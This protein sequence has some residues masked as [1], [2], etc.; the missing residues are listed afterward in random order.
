[1]QY[2]KDL[3]I[4][5]SSIEAIKD[6]VLRKVSNDP[7]ILV[8]SN[9]NDDGGQRA[10]GIQLGKE[11]SEFWEVKA[12][13]G[14][15]ATD[16]NNFISD[17]MGRAGNKTYLDQQQKYFVRFKHV[18]LNIKA[19]YHT[20]SMKKLTSMFNKWLYW[21]DKLSFKLKLLDGTFEILVTPD[22]ATPI[23]NKN[24][25]AAENAKLEVNFVMRT[26]AGVIYK[27]GLMKSVRFNTILQNADQVTTDEELI[28]VD[29]HWK[30]QL[31][32]TE[33]TE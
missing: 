5:D 19:V 16:M 23:P 31:L 7:K 22:E 29:E 9:F 18:N 2:F 12:I 14:Q 21:Q 32:T 33:E 3:P 25:E 8:V 1:M 30:P 15:V 6:A 10:A 11:I 28:I 26:F 20:Q 4:L 24:L 27:T 17:R 13:D